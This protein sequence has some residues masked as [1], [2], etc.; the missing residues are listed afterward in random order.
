MATSFGYEDSV[1]TKLSVPVPTLSYAADY[2][3]KNE[4]A[5]QV[6]LTNTTSPLDQPEDLRF[7]IQKVANVYSG[8]P[9]ALENQSVTK[10]GISLLTQNYEILRVTPEM[11]E[12]AGCCCSGPFDLPIRFHSVLVVPINQYVT[13]D[14]AMEVVRRG[15]AMYYN[16]TLSNDRL[17]EMLRGSLK[18]SGM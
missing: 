15:M 10:Q 1:Q 14:V 16:G 9:V 8:S 2:A 3:V 12:A 18:P 4:T 5:G 17:N 6:I 13:A 11:A 7:Q